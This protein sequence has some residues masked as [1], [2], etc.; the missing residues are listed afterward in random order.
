MLDSLLEFDSEQDIIA[1][2]G[3]NSISTDTGSL[4]EGMGIYLYNKLNAGTE[5]EVS[6]VWEDE[7]KMTDLAYVEIS[8]R[9]SDWRTEQGVRLGMLLPVLQEI[10]QEPFIFYGF[11]WDY[12]GTISDYQDGNLEDKGINIKLAL[13]QGLKPAMYQPLSGDIRL[14]SDTMP[15]IK[16][17]TYVAVITLQTQE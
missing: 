3:P 17:R 7:E 9:S 14:K 11:E 4:P 5:N 10:N 15:A 6:F 16:A 1:A 12:S 8:G 13:P 2:F